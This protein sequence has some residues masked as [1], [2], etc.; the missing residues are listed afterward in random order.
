MAIVEM[1]DRTNS[2]SIRGIL[3]KPNGV[4]AMWC[5]WSELGDFLAP[6]GIYQ[7]RRRVR[8][9]D[10][11]FSAQLGMIVC[12][13]NF[14]GDFGLG[15]EILK[16]KPRVVVKLKHY[17]TGNPRTVPQQQWRDYFR[18]VLAIWH[19]LTD[20]EKSFY[21]IDTKHG[22]MGAWNRYARAYMRRK[23]SDVGNTICGMCELGYLTN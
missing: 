16:N 18:R 13:Y 9:I 6:A 10:T 22:G 5:G 1:Q 8:R 2:L 21:Y 12:G 19:A 23:P 11:P 15:F 14:L 17:I 20:D 7:T 3:G 4:G